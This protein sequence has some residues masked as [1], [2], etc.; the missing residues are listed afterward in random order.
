MPIPPSDSTLWSVVSSLAKL[1]VLISLAVGVYVFRAPHLIWFTI[2]AFNRLPSRLAQERGR[3]DRFTQATS[4]LAGL[5]YLKDLFVPRGLGHWV[6]GD[7]PPGIPSDHERLKSQEAAAGEAAKLLLSGRTRIVIFTGK[8]GW[9]KTYT[10]HSLRNRLA[11][12]AQISV[13]WTMISAN[14]ESRIVEEFINV[15]KTATAGRPVSLAFDYL[16]AISR[17]NRSKTSPHFFA[18]IHDFEA[19]AVE[20]QSLAS[21]RRLIERVEASEHMSLV[22]TTRDPGERLA[23]LLPVL[24][25][26]LVK[27]IE[28]KGPLPTADVRRLSPREP[29]SP[30]VQELSPLQLT[31][32]RHYYKYHP[33]RRSAVRPGN[34]IDR[35]PADPAELYRLLFADLRP[36][37]QVCLTAAPGAAG[38]VSRAPLPSQAGG[39]AGGALQR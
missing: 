22:I 4:L 14:P 2:R 25:S 31:L 5:W 24:S 18:H 21:A 6:F 30:A 37:R 12:L 20:S 38:G 19:I 26:N 28:I 33:P 29:V 8:A 27:L 32:R 39:A 36:S 3:R 17:G 10:S 16:E 7:V 9:G 23:K 15:S 1:S 35:T 11:P 34:I 13:S